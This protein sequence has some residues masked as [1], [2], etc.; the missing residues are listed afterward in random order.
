M[1]NK[2]ANC[3][4]SFEVTP[5]TFTLKVFCRIYWTFDGLMYKSILKV[6]TS[7]KFHLLSCS[8]LF[9]FSFTLER[10]LNQSS[11]VRTF[12][13]IYHFCRLKSSAVSA[14]TGRKRKSC[15]WKYFLWTIQKRLQNKNEIVSEINFHVIFS[16]FKNEIW[17][18]LYSLKSTWNR[19]PL[20]TRFCACKTFSFRFFLFSLHIFAE[21]CVRQWDMRYSH[22]IFLSAP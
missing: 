9:S 17:C 21:T 18:F 13:S 19:F 3:R 22:I 4:K 2:W 20:S 14:I 7:I 8:K 10:N 11:L 12:K 5:F 1:L 15:K 6:F 16:S